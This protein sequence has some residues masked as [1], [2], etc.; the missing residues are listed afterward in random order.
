MWGRYGSFLENERC[1]ITFLIAASH[2][3]NDICV[4]LPTVRAKRT[5]MV[6][7]SLE[8]FFT[9]EFFS[10]TYSACSF[11]CVFFDL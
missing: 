8:I 6:P 5:Q 4:F 7:I 11:V 3:A 2:R 1:I 9:G 10:T